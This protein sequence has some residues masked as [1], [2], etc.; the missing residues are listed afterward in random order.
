MST[1][2]APRFALSK[3][4]RKLRERFEQ[5]RSMPLE[6]RLVGSDEYQFTTNWGKPFLANWS[7]YLSEFKG[8]E[9]VHMLEIGS[10]EGRSAL[11]FLANILTHQSSTL[12]CVDP[13]FRRPREIRFDHNMKCSGWQHKVTKIKARSDHVVYKLARQ[14]FDIIYIDGDHRAKGVLIDAVASWLCLK[15]GGV[16]I[17]DDYKWEPE[18]PASDRPQMAIDMFLA[19]FPDQ[20]ELLHQDYQ[21]IVRKRGKP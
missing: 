14:S 7:R 12:T 20:I 1:I 8:K 18:K 11:W 16:M 2:A 9:N 6:R 10:F 5:I 4:R 15:P 17:F 21:V 3:M 19:S 13:F